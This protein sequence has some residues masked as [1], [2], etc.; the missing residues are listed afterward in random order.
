MI[1]DNLGKEV[2]HTGEK[3]V[4]GSAYGNFEKS[5]RKLIVVNAFSNNNMSKEIL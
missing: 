2:K 1:G 3:E 5:Y 4:K